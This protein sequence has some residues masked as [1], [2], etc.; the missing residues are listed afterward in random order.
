MGMWGVEH[1]YV[2][3]SE[4][5]RGSRCTWERGLMQGGVT[6]LPPSLEYS[7]LSW[8]NGMV[9]SRESKE[10]LYIQS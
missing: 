4:S 3:R 9:G 8:K 1:F 2:G 6:N 10:R 5:E 7:L